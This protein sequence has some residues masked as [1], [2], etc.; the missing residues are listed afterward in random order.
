MTDIKAHVPDLET[1]KMLKEA[2]FPQE[3]TIVWTKDGYISMNPYLRDDG[4]FIAAPLATEI[5]EGLPDKYK[6]TVQ[7]SPCLTGYDIF[8]YWDENI[9]SEPYTYHENPATACAL[10]WLKLREENKL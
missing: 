8:F 3:T 7:L 1:C 9:C 2:G 10:M 6:N 5:M 4:Y